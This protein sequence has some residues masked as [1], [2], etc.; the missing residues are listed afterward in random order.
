[1]QLILNFFGTLWSIYNFKDPDMDSYAR[2]QLIAETQQG[3]KVMSTLLILLILIAMLLFKQMSLINSF[4]LNYFWVI[5]LATHI[6]VSARIVKDIKT[7]HALGITLLVISATAYVFIA[8]QAGGFSPLLL[9]NIVLL[10]MIIPMVPWGLREALLVILAIYTLLTFS[11]LSVGGRFDSETLKVLQFFLL[12]AGSTSL[13]LVIRATLVRK[14][15]LLAHFRL[16]KA[17]AEMH[18]MANVDP[19]TGAWNRRYITEGVDNLVKRFRGVHDQLHFIIFDLDK[20]KVL[21]DTF[22]HDFGDR[23]LLIVSKQITQA[24]EEHGYLIRIG[25]DEFVLL[26]VGIEPEAFLQS[27]RQQ[28]FDLVR[29]EKTKAVFGMSWG[30]VSVPLAPLKDAEGV[31]QLADQALYQHK[32]SPQV[33]PAAAACN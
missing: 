18:A 11:T 13:I 19:L 2:E 17:H 12:A 32:Q 5:A 25:G 31:Y 28:V 1:M 27:I 10:F 7:L 4:S 16:H 6:N 33:N 23:V 14:K 29:Q 15:E 26:L 8:H 9:A 30:I 22:G 20:F 21:N 24:I 3:L